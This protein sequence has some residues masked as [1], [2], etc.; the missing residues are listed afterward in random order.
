MR[1]WYSLLL[2]LPVVI[3]GNNL[4]A[5]GGFLAVFIAGMTF[6]TISIAS[7]EAAVFVRRV[8]HRQ[9]TDVSELTGLRHHTA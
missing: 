2:G 9:R 5:G 3:G 4:R 1:W 7:M 8:L 6:A